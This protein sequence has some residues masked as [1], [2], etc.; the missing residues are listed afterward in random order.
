MPHVQ[1]GALTCGPDSMFQAVKHLGITQKQ[2]DDAYGLESVE[3]F[4][5]MQD[6]PM[7]AADSLDK[8]GVKW[9]WVDVNRMMKMECCPGKTVILLH[10][11]KNPIFAQHWAVVEAF[12]GSGVTLDMGTPDMIAKTYAWAQLKALYT[13]GGPTNTAYEVLGM[14]EKKKVNIF[15]RFWAF[16]SAKFYR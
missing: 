5:N 8:L 9:R 4:G 14:V 15:Y 11:L 13:A 1:R 10:S 12:Y 7:N 6:T 3:S 16:I 2:V